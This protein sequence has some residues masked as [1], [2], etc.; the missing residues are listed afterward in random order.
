MLIEKIPIQE[1]NHFDYVYICSDINIFNYMTNSSRFNIE[2]FNHIFDINIINDVSVIT[3]DVIAETSNKPCIYLY[4]NSY[5]Y[6]NAATSKFN[7]TKYVTT[8]TDVF[9]SFFI[10]K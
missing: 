9:F 2:L 3:H 7:R 6:Y 10:N 8:K 4:Q 5:F 1:Y